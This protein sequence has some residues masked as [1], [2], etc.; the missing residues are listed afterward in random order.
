VKRKHDRIHWRTDQ[1]GGKVKKTL[2][3]LQSEEVH[4]VGLRH[5]VLRHKGTHEMVAQAFEVFD[6]L[7]N[8]DCWTKMGMKQQDGLAYLPKTGREGRVSAEKGRRYGPGSV[9]GNWQAMALLLASGGGVEKRL[10]K[11]SASSKREN[12]KVFDK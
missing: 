11:A 5:T 9:A 8:P 12:K 7:Q 10:L 3:D 1:D 6:P 4:K 2:E